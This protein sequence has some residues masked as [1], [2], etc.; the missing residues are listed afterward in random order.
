MDDRNGARLR[1]IEGGASTVTRPAI[2][3]SAPGAFRKLPLRLVEPMS[4]F[5][6]ARR[7]RST[8]PE[9]VVLLMC[10]SSSRMSLEQTDPG[11]EVPLTP[12]QINSLESLDLD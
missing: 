1:L 2:R 12:E 6:L 9:N 8:R 7:V 3:A 11:I 4:D 5:E 10:H